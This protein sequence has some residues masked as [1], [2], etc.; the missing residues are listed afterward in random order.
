MH[1]V[2]FRKVTPFSEKI[3]PFFLFAKNKGLLFLLDF[4]MI[5]LNQPVAYNRYTLNTAV[6]WAR[7]GFRY[8]CT[9]SPSLSQRREIRIFYITMLCLI[10]E[11]NS[12]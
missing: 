8:V 5:I 2:P 11:R 9:Y 10:T 1:F 7:D 4:G 12:T 3:S 6:G